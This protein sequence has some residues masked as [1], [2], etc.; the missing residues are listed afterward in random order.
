MIFYERLLPDLGGRGKTVLVIMHDDRYFHVADRCVELDA[1]QLRVRQGQR[2]EAA[3]PRLASVR[4][5]SR[6]GRRRRRARAPRHVRSRRG[7]AVPRATRSGR[8]RSSTAPRARPPGRRRPCSSRDRIA[9]DPS[10]GGS[11]TGTRLCQIASL[12][13]ADTQ[14]YRLSEITPYHRS[15]VLSGRTAPEQDKHAPLQSAIDVAD[16]AWLGDDGNLCG[17]IQDRRRCDRCEPRGTC[18]SGSQRRD[19]Q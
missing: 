18:C 13:D 12:F 9:S 14:M 8:S 16:G 2:R 1:G 5:P 17:G 6:V 19:S 15:S 3:E 10:I 11:P 4:G 7:H